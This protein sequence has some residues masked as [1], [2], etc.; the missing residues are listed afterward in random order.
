MGY[1]DDVARIG[2]KPSGDFLREAVAPFEGGRARVALACCGTSRIA[3]LPVVHVQRVGRV[4]GMKADG[5][6]V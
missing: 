5:V 4:G 1:Q 6:A 3:D 2:G